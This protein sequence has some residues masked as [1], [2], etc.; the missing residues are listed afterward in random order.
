MN[1]V[2]ENDEHEKILQE[3][4]KRY[5]MLFQYMQNGFSLHEIIYNERGKPCDYRFLEVNPAF[6]RLTG[7]MAVDIVGKTILEVLPGTEIR[8]IEACGKVALSGKSAHF[9]HFSAELQQY[10]EV[11]IY[12]PLLG[13]LATIFTNVTACRKAEDK[14][15]VSTARIR[16]MLDSAADAVLVTNP[17]ARFVYVNQKA[18][19]LVGY[20]REE[21]LLMSV[22]DLTPPELIDNMLHGFRTALVGENLHI[23]GALLNKSGI[24]VPV[25]LNVVLLPDGNVFGSAR[26]ITRRKQVDSLIKHRLE[27]RD[28]A[29]TSSVDELIQSMLD[30]AEKLTNSSIGLFY[31]VDE[32]QQY[33]L[34]EAG[35]T[36]TISTAGTTFKRGSNY[37]I[38]QADVWGECFHK[39]KPM[40]RNECS[41]NHFRSKM[42]AFDSHVT[43]ELVV[44]VIINNKVISI[45]GISNKP[46]PYTQDDIYVVIERKKS[47][48]ERLELERQFQ[49]N[50]KQESLGV[51]AGGIAHDINNILTIILGHCFLAKEKTEVATTTHIL[52]IET[53]TKRAADFCQQLLA[54]AGKNQ[55]VQTDVNMWMLVNEMAGLLKTAIKNN[56]TIKLDLSRDILNIQGNLSQ[57]QQVVMNLIINASEAIGD[58]VPGE[59]CVTVAMT[60]VEPGQPI[61]DHIGHALPTGKYVCLGVSDNG[62]GMSDETKQRFFEPCY[63]TK[64]AGHGLGMSA[65]LGIIK[66]HK[67]A[68]KLSSVPGRGTI[69]KV[70]L[71]VNIKQPTGYSDEVGHA[72][73]RCAAG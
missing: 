19:E 20:S 61:R 64:I 27:L 52:Q 11:E 38:C 45:I 65:A 12:S 67:G 3:S 43:R 28:K 44:P 39:R 50:Q 14:I 4:E 57:I 59:I 30:S 21:L 70:Y 73:R 62:C 72:L 69:F 26:D 36:K 18:L 32:E 16:T 10:Y 5:R 2:T 31:K 7:L 29:V 15:K 25:D 51:L 13:Q 1:G 40:I 60:D 23:E 34:L 24:L 56:I 54:Y 41:N 49:Q 42:L 47:E 37:P 8:W 46:S 55:P 17:L 6:E 63:T 58:D 22:A 33:L 53:A 66:T 48:E 9:E 35:S 68:L 71:P